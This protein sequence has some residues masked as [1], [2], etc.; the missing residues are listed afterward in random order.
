MFPDWSAT[1]EIKSS[2]W[3]KD[4]SRPLKFPPNRINLRGAWRPRDETNIGLAYF[5][6]VSSTFSLK[7]TSRAAACIN[8]LPQSGVLK[9]HGIRRKHARGF[10][11]FTE[12]EIE[13]SPSLDTGWICTS[14]FSQ[15]GHAVYILFSIV[16]CRYRWVLLTE[17]PPKIN[18][19]RHKYFTQ[20]KDT[21]I[22]RA[23]RFILISFLC[24][25]KRWRTFLPDFDTRLCHRKRAP[26]RLQFNRLSSKVVARMYIVTGLDWSS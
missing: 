7:N 12:A 15:V 16:F 20:R 6:S 11:S 1:E 13:S 4:F 14:M 21:K 23:W 25:R 18:C 3:P 2:L 26:K 5:S 10:R 9:F 8:A 22:E 17:Y 19:F 24:R